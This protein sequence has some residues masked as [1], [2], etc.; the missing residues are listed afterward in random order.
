MHEQAAG[1]AYLPNR[2]IDRQGRSPHDVLVVH[3]RDHADDATRHGLAKVRI[4]PPQVP[5]HRVT[6]REQPLCDALADDRYEFA[7]AA[8]IVREVAAGSHRD[9]EHG[10]EAGRDDAEPRVRI[11]FPIRGRVTLD[12]ELDTGAEAAGIA[13]G[14]EAPDRD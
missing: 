11:L 2:L 7:A 5:V 8:V 9:A 14:H 12:G 13:P 6:V 3:V 4:G 1:N 10:E